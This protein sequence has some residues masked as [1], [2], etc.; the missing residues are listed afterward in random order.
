ME[1]VAPQRCRTTYEPSF[2]SASYARQGSLRKLG[3][4]GSPVGTLTPGTIGSVRL[5]GMLG[6]KAI[7]SLAV[8]PSGSVWP[9][10]QIGWVPLGAEIVTR[11]REPA[12]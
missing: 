1:M 11:T 10:D 9:N 2:T 12:R 7:D 6:E 5:E 3:Q 8:A 4:A